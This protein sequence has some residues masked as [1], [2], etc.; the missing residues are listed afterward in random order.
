MS[1]AHN[2]ARKPDQRACQKWIYRKDLLEK[3]TKRKKKSQV[4]QNGKIF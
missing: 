2:L 1:Q 4:R 3:L